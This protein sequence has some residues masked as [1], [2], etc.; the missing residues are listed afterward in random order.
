MSQLRG[1]T[2]CCTAP[3]FAPTYV[4]S[5]KSI[6]YGRRPLHGAL[7]GIS[8]KNGMSKGVSLP[9]RIW[10]ITSSHAGGRNCPLLLAKR[11]YLATSSDSKT[12]YRVLTSHGC[13]YLQISTSSAKHNLEFYVYGVTPES[14]GAEALFAVHLL[15]ACRVDLGL[16]ALGHLDYERILETFSTE[17]MLFNGTIEPV[18]VVSSR[19]NGQ[20]IP[21]IQEMF[22]RKTPCYL[23]GRDRL[24]EMGALGEELLSHPKEVYRLLWQIIQGVLWNSCVGGKSLSPSLEK[25]LAE[26]GSEFCVRRIQ[27]YL[28]EWEST[29]LASTE[30]LE[31]SCCRVLS[32]TS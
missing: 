9:F 3:A 25:V 30:P 14:A 8:K 4:Y 15:E 16:I 18:E 28:H 7:H 13:Q 20:Y 26:E 1:T 22:L 11:R 31:V 23:I 21:V 5:G 6:P 29:P 32:M 17:K 12:R 24:V 10:G 27:Q 19:A 2:T